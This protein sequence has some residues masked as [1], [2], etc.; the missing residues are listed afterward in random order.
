M[1]SVIVGQVVRSAGAAPRQCLA[2]PAMGGS[3]ASSRAP[4]S[5]NAADVGELAVSLVAAL[6][7]AEL[8]VGAGHVEDVVDDLEEH[9]EL[10]RRTR[11]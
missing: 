8:L 1:K 10:A 3:A 5:P 11:R 9:A 2:G 7:L 4:S 6:R